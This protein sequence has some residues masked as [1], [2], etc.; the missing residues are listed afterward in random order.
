MA[1][2]CRTRHIFASIA[3]QTFGSM[4]CRREEVEGVAGEGT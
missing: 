1:R 3:L 4:D 2:Y